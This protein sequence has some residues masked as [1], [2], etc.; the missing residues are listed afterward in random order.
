MS[1]LLFRMAA[2]S[3]RRNRRRTLI[4]ASS[5]AFSVWLAV[6]FVG[7]RQSTYAR[8]L[9][10]GTRAGFG[11]MT[12]AHRAHFEG[13]AARVGVEAAKA[14][15][16]GLEGVR[17]AHPRVA[18]RAVVAT[19]TKS[20]GAALLGIEPAS[21]RAD[22]N[23]MLAAH[24]AGERLAPGD[25]QGCYAG[26]ALAAHLGLELGGKLVYTTT[27]VNGE[28]VSQVAYLRG[29]FRTGSGELDGHTLLLPLA[30]LR[31]TLGYG[32]GEASFVAVYFDEDSRPRLPAPAGDVE[33][34]SW[35]STLPD[36]AN[37]MRIDEA[38]YRVLLLFIALIVA[39]GIL[40]TMMLS[41]LERRRELGVVLALG[42][43]PA[44]LVLLV[45]LEAAMV[46]GLGLALGAV[47]VAPFYLYLSRVGFDV[48][49]LFGHKLDAGGV[50]VDFVLGCKLFIQDV[51]AIGIVLAALTLAAAAFPAARAA[52]TDPITSIREP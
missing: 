33:A 18:T 23:L 11:E 14:Q 42:M 3:F 17:A 27:A 4:T 36:L 2:R 22:T 13:A 20:T 9:D 26:A 49:W 52:L 28:M 7:T 5:V 48:S 16:A 24:L 29:I 10:A 21:E 12:I 35:H 39:S 1:S 15:L 44:G 31:H 30:S 25:L 45:T 19:A 40:N 32:A 43:T 41:V 37:F 50:A 46:A 6:V 51:Q 47:T 34:R 8:L 38:F